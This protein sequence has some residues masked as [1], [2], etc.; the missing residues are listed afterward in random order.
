MET[1]KFRKPFLCMAVS[2]TGK[3]EYHYSEPKS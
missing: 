1:L 2:L 3:Y